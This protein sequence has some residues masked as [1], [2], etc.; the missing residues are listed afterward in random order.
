MSDF[1]P[2]A[3][4]TVLDFSHVI[5]GPMATFYLRQL[6]AN[7]QK[8]EPR[9]GGDVLRSSKPET[10]AALNAGK[11]AIAADLRNPS[12][13]ATLK[14]LASMADVV[15]DSLRPGVLEK[16]GLGADALRTLHPRL[17]YC[18]ISG[19]GQRGPWAG[20][21]AYDHVIQAATGMAMMAGSEG[22][23]PIK[24]GFPVIDAASGILAALAI[25]A[26]LRERDQTGR[27]RHIDV[28]MSAAALQLMY[29]MA[30]TALTRGVVPER[31]GNR[32]YSLSPAADMFETNDGWIAIGANTP[33]QFMALLRLLDLQALA[34]DTRVFGQ[35]LS[36]D[37]PAAFLRAK[38]PALLRSAIAAAIHRRSADQLEEACA[39]INV[40]AAKVR[41]LPEFAELAQRHD[42]L[43]ILE[44]A[45]DE[46][47]VRSPGLGFRV[48]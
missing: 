41:T 37:A 34:N 33:R 48:S 23:G 47:S 11:K 12:D 44:M 19:Y 31:I 21:P 15:V 38:D 30:S 39:Q 29:P 42:G 4:V 16:Y 36:E 17:V 43:G 8:V 7:V 32:G 26:A 28:A 13:L 9:A 35:P 14:D 20:R 18:S 5:A 6:G 2:L 25:V 3:D 1:Q 46:V 45:G 24:T 10:F 40:A 27:G 22:D